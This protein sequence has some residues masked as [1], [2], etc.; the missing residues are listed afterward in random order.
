MKL[1]LRLGL[2]C[3]LA[4]PAV[5]GVLAMEPG[6][7]SGVGDYGETLTL[8]VQGGMGEIEVVTEG[9]QGD[10]RGV[11]E[12]VAEGQWQMRPGDLPGCVIG[13]AQKGDAIVVTEGS[14]CFGL[15]GAMCTFGG[16]LTE[17]AMPMVSDPVMA[18]GGDAPGVESWTYGMDPE[19]G[20][21]AHIRTPEGAV[22]LA[23]L[24]DGSNPATAWILGVRMSPALIGPEGA[25]YM[26]D[27]RTDALGIDG[28]AGAAFAEKKDTTCGVGLEAFRAAQS[29]VL[30]DGMIAAI[31]SGASGM[32]IS[33]D[34]G[35]RRT[36]VLDG[37]DAAAKL[38]GRRISLKGSSAA[39][40]ALLRD[41]PFAQYDID[42]NCGL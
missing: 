3:V 30:I 11:M 13:F 34:Q 20:L 16:K 26:F 15:H 25:V 22:G 9:C 18:A 6:Q 29:M 12:P 23:C 37:T 5:Q 1:A 40:K 7:Y 41:C 19:L 17:A 36:V 39:I 10:T 27:G 32:E 33:I 4:M 28:A 2:G 35:G 8:T 14:E 21:S 38:G 31:N 24:A 42:T